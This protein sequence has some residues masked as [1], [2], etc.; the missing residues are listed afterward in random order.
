MKKKLLTLILSLSFC[1]ACASHPDFKNEQNQA[2][3][4]KLYQQYLST[5]PGDDNLDMSE[6]FRKKITLDTFKPIVPHLDIEFS[7]EEIQHNYKKTGFIRFRSIDPN[8]R[9]L[10]I[11]CG[12]KPTDR[13]YNYQREFNFDPLYRG[14]HAH[15]GAT[16]IDPDPKNNPTIIAYFGTKPLSICKDNS[17][18]KI[19]IETINIPALLEL[20]Y[21][22]PD[23]KR[24]LSKNGRLYLSYNYGPFHISFSGLEKFG[25]AWVKYDFQEGP[26]PTDGANKKIIQLLPKTFKNMIDTHGNQKVKRLLQTF[27]EEI[28]WVHTNKTWEKT[29]SIINKKSEEHNALWTRLKCLF[30][31]SP[32]PFTRQESRLIQLIDMELYTP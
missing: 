4:V 13:G 17:F 10:V 15:P 7:L 32:T 24:L 14:A 8:S 29:F 1:I 26:S 6:W 28:N 21:F 23:L 27:L 2:D 22:I 12:N 18:D 25:K 16:T 19:L 31:Y 11:G 5:L 9:T 20:E 3:F 30:G